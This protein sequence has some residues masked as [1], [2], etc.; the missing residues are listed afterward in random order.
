METTNTILIQ[1]DEAQL[2]RFINVA[3]NS[4]VKEYIEQHIN[5]K[6]EKSVSAREC[7]QYFGFS[8]A[9]VMI[10]KAKKGE[11][12]AYQFN[13]KKSPYKFYL[14]EVDKKLRENKI[15]TLIY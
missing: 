13:G 7:A 11:V 15:D 5:N 8:H 2:K 3:V 10:E 14:S 6:I 9:S 12:P 4:A 1:I